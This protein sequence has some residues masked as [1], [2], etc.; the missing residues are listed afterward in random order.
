M[1]AAKIGA[2]AKRSRDFFALSDHQRDKW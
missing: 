1:I 2:V